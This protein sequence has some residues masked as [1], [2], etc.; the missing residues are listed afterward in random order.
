[1]NESTSSFFFRCDTSSQLTNFVEFSL[2]SICPDHHQNGECNECDLN[3]EAVIISLFYQLTG[4]DGNNVTNINACNFN[5]FIDNT[6]PS[7]SSN[8]RLYFTKSLSM[9][10]QHTH[11]QSIIHQLAIHLLSQIMKN[12]TNW[13]SRLSDDI[14]LINFI[15]KHI[16]D[17]N[18]N[19]MV[20][21][22]QILLQYI[23]ANI[24]I[25][26]IPQI[27]YLVTDF[28]ECIISKHESE[29]NTLPKLIILYNIIKSKHGLAI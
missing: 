27:K 29:E 8:D 11:I 25:R 19:D 18:N 6:L 10:I 16:L 14:R 15:I 12:N 2:K 5:T 26:K 24:A 21:E 1:M 9:I 13:C 7:Y 23:S 3:L 28:I 20:Y 17:S 22:Y 4:V